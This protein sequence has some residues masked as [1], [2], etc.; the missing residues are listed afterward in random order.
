MWKFFLPICFALFF[1][2]NCQRNMFSVT[3]DPVS[4]VDHSSPSE[5][6]VIDS[7]SISSLSLLPNKDDSLPSYQNQKHISGFQFFS[8]YRANIND[9]SG[10]RVCDYPSLKSCRSETDGP[11]RGTGIWGPSGLNSKAKLHRMRFDFISNKYFSNKP[12]GHIAFGIRG[13]LTLNSNGDPTSVYGRGFVIGNLSAAS[14]N[15]SNP[16]CQFRIAQIESFFGN[17]QIFPETCSD[18]IFLDGRLYSLELLVSSDGKIGYKVYD[19]Q[20]KQIYSSLIKDPNNNLN[21]N[22]TGWFSGHVLDGRVTSPEGNWNYII[23]DIILDESNTVNIEDEFRKL[24]ISTFI[25]QI[26]V[27]NDSVARAFLDEVSIGDFTNSRTRVFGCAGPIYNAKNDCQNISNFRVMY[28]Q[29]DT[30]QIIDETFKRVGSRIVIRHEI[31]NNL[32]K[33][34]YRL[35]L[36][37]NPADTRSEIRFLIDSR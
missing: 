13:D 11:S 4:N 37:L 33:D 21:P 17:N 16:A 5:P 12:G 22:F 27:P 3:N 14:P 26:T 29:T 18:S 7:A 20:K 15:I 30:T 1:F 6:T 34:L 19:D 32:P 8:E 10:N 2:Q 25:N 28:I 9:V 35:T 23:K 24:T 36:R 31:L